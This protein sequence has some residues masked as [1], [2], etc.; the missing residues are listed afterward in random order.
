[1]QRTSVKILFLSLSI[2]LISTN[3]VFSQKKKAPAKKATAP[4]KAANP[5][6]TPATSA[7]ASSANPF[8]NAPA[9]S[10]QPPKGAGATDPFS[11]SSSKT[12]G[13]ATDPFAAS[14]PAGGSQPPANKS[15]GGN[16]Q[17]LVVPSTTSNPLS[18]S[19]RPALRNASAIISDIKDR[20]PLAYDDIR[21]DDAIYRHKIWKVI[22]A[23][24]KINAPFIYNEDEGSMLFFSIVFKA[25][26]EDSVLAFEDDKFRKPYKDIN[27]F[28]AKFSGGVDTS[29]VYD[30][31]GQTLLRREVRSKE[32]PVDSVYEFMVMEETIFDKEAARLV[33]RIIGIAPM[34]PTILPSGKVIEGPH[35]PYFWIY[36][37]DLRKTLAKKQVY[38]AKNL[39]ARMTWEDYLENH[40]FSYY[41]VK[42]SM[43]NVKDQNLK[44]YIKDPMFRLFEGEKIKDKIFNYEQ[45]L[46]AY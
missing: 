43:D 5:F 46:W 18:D 19:A 34:G 10:S 14:K 44:E 25:V 21:E 15:A 11:S 12:G 31:D 28:K 4:A 22:D 23:R 42:S 26:T 29:D 16:V 36:Y 37:P 17:I 13:G 6:G 20:N 3:S 40:H 38:N 7:P 9:G 27:K 32:F 1:M 30:I 33:H 24:E 2:C 45:G 41:I 39:G 35:F 8:G